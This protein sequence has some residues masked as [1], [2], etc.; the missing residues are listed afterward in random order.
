MPWPMVRL[1][2]VCEFRYGRALPA[3]S[4]HAGGIG[5]YGSNGQ[6]GAHDA[7]I[8][9][10]PT[11][12]VGRKGSVG[13]V[14]LSPEACWPIDT[15][16]YVDETAT[17]TDLR[18]LAYRLRGLGLTQM[19]KAA[20]VP[21]LSRDDA[22]RLQLLLPPIEEQRRIADILDRADAIRAMRREAVAHLDDLTNSIFLDMFV[23]LPRDAARWPVATVGDLLA[24]PLRNGLSPA[25]NGTVRGRVL[26]LSAITGSGFDESAVKDARFAHSP[27]ENQRVR[28]CDLL[29]CRGNGN[30]KLVGRGFFPVTDAPDV[31]YPD[32]AIAATFVTDRVD[33][34]YVEHVWNSPSVR[35]QVES[36]AHTTNGTFKINQAMVESIAL[37]LPAIETQRSF[38]REASDIDALRRSQ[39]KAL[40]TLDVVFAALQQRAFAG[41][42]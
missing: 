30:R 31:T 13:E 42:L 27:A 9:S 17:N 8:T 25:T 7:S 41:E 14:H 23:R 37:D 29:I 36:V 26:T 21:G 5:V 16:Y 3:A 39:R 19:N 28:S 15:T 40:D 20:A 38:A 10:G 12:I 35:R 18:W 4:R 24:E 6:V 22:Y 32:T 1:S 33:R 11:I 34:S 2:D